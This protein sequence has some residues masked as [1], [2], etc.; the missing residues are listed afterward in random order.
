VG[1]CRWKE[2]AC[3]WNPDIE[4]NGKCVVYRDCLIP[5]Y[6]CMKVHAEEDRC[7]QCEPVYLEVWASWARFFTPIRP[8]WRSVPGFVDTCTEDDYEVKSEDEGLEL[9]AEEQV[10]QSPIACFLG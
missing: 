8:D 4:C 6:L 2:G 1:F 3:G 5:F 9:L 7:S 10:G